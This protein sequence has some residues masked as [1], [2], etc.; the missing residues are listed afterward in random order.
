MAPFDVGDAA[1]NDKVDGISNLLPSD[2]RFLGSLQKGS[3][4][5][6]CR[7]RPNHGALAVKFESLR[8]LADSESGA[9]VRRKG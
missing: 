2:E 3:P 8:A 9:A 6:G 4:S 5:T 1:S 7:R